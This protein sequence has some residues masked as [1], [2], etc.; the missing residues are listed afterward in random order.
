MNQ[1][2]EN[3]KT[4]RSERA[5]KTGVVISA[6]LL[7]ELVAGAEVALEPLPVPLAPPLDV[8][9]GIAVPFVCWNILIY[10]NSKYALSKFFG[11]ATR[12][13]HVPAQVSAK[14]LGW[15]AKLPQMVVSMISVW[16]VKNWS[17]LQDE[18]G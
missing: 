13:V 1:R 6:S 11:S 9:V 8:V 4:E 12:S 18:F 17:K 5:V 7:L 14:T 2:R 3:T 10:A 15:P 16:G